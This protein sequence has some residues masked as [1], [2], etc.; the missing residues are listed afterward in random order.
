[1]SQSIIG[2]AGNMIHDAGETLYHLPVSYIPQGY[3][4]AVQKAGGIPLLLPI[5]QP[6]FAKTYIQQIDKLILAGGQ[7][8]HPKYYGQ[9]EE[10]DSNYLTCRD[11]FELSLVEEAVR[12]EKPI[13][14]VC[15]GMQLL[16]VYFGGSLYQDIEDMTPVNHMQNPI[17]REEPTHD[18]MIEKQSL[19]YPIYG[20]QS[21][22]NSFHHQAVK[23]VGE[24]LTVTAQCSD[25]IVEAIENSKRRILGVQWHPDF[26][27]SKQPQEQA[28]FQ[29][30]VNQL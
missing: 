11:Q 20:K 2:I 16:N 12:Q 24:S 15:R 5:G 30:V 23:E 17:P 1:M 21:K 4:E 18:L 8:I 28:V 6:E 27:Y 25:G 14:A 13:F 22:V 19:L 9:S 10:I 26:A 3:I 29:Y 7:D